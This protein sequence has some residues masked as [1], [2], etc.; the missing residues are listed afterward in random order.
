MNITFAAMKKLWTIEQYCF[1][2]NFGTRE[3]NVRQQKPIKFIKN[4]DFT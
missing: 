1:L 2:Y 4:T 3:D